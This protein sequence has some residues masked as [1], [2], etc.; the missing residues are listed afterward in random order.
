MLNT[1]MHHFKIKFGTWMF[2][3]LHGEAL[4]IIGIGSFPLAE[5]VVLFDN[6]EDGEANVFL[7]SNFSTIQ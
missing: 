2:Y 4:F 6:D 7:L 5:P 3:F 1:A